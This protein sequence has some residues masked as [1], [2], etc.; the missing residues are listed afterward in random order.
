MFEKRIDKVVTHSG[1]EIFVM[2]L[3]V[4]DTPIYGR[5]HVIPELHTIIDA[6]G[7]SPMAQGDLE[8]GFESLY[9]QHG[10]KFTPSDVECVLL[11]HGHKDH[12][13]GLPLFDNPKCQSYLHFLDSEMVCRSAE[14]A[15][16]A[17]RKL[18][19][20]Y[21]QAC[22]PQSDQPL[23]S[24]T[25][26]SMWLMS[27]SYNIDNLISNHDTIGPFT[28]LHTPCHT[29][30]HVCYCL[31]NVMFTGDQLMSQTN[32]PPLWPRLFSPYQ[33]YRNYIQSMQSIQRAIIEQGIDILLPSHEETVYNPNQ[34][35]KKIKNAEIR[36]FKRIMDYFGIGDAGMPMESRILSANQNMLPYSTQFTKEF[37]I[38]P[39]NHLYVINLFDAACRMEFID[40]QQ[41]HPMAS[42]GA[43]I[44]NEPVLS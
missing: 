37:Y 22:I 33:G 15:A 36:R 2:H 42:L 6:G 26:E 10:I 21:K 17:K 32:T 25:F 9:Q 13:G 7:T 35:I 20:F 44:H 29:R 43:I 19:F 27:D 23:I 41:S 11:T 5:V 3:R 4:L 31:D 39:T 12:I 24:D 30:G 28:V 1:I 8:E 14:F 18:D 16:Q 40:S 34:R 38:V